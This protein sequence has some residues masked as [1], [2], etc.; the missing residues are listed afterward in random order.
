M[1]R[2]SL[3][4]HVQQVEDSRKKRGVR[5]VRRPRTQDQAGPSH[6][7]HG[8]NFVI[9]EQPRFSKG[10]Q[11]LG[12]LTLR[13]VHHIE[14]AN[15]N[16]RG[17]MALRVQKGTNACFGCG[18]SG[19]MVRDCPQ[20]RGQAGGNAQTR[21]NPQSEAAAEPPKRNRFYDMKGR[22]EQDKSTDVVTGSTLSFLTSLLA[23]TFE[24]LPEVLHYPIVVKIEDLKPSGLT[25]IIEDLT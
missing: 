14:E 10:Q 13:G 12:I 22:E 5:D 2:S 18:K 17:A 19:H 24:I 9:R 7:G 21:P 23:L 15:L 3:M 8:N 11:I 6:R 4:V 1:D 20:N 25:Q 16:P